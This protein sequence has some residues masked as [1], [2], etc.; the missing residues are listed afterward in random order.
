MR[1]SIAAGILI[2]LAS[3]ANVCI[4]NKYIAAFLFSFALLTICQLDLSL[5]T[6]K[7][8]YVKLETVLEMVKILIGNLLGVYIISFV[9]NVVIPPD[10]VIRA[11]YLLE[12][13]L[14]LS[15]SQICYSSLLCGII[16]FLVTYNFK[17]QHGNIS[18][19]VTLVLGI[20][21]F[22]LC[23]FDHCIADFSYVMLAGNLD[24]N[25][26]DKVKLIMMSSFYNGVGAFGMRYL[27]MQK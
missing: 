13:K 16:I 8:A 20:A 5:Y 26:L 27:I 24:S 25:L 11:R 9:I 10:T 1:R 23:K 3:Y 7:I 22:V 4:E 12:T 21:L 6:G 15:L 17:L 19:I 18:S 14:S 2:G